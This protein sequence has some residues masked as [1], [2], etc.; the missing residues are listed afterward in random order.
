MSLFKPEFK[1]GDYV[2]IRAGAYEGYRGHIDSKTGKY[3]GIKLGECLRVVG[4]SNDQL[5]EG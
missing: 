5:E 3:Y 2:R 1:I 4:Y